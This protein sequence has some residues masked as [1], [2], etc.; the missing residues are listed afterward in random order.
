MARNLPVSNK[1]RKLFEL[2]M[3]TAAI[4]EVRGYYHGAVITRGSRVLAQGI[5][6]K[7]KTHPLA[8]SRWTQH[9]EFSVIMRLGLDYLREQ[10]KTILYSAR[11]G[12]G[13]VPRMS[14]PCKNCMNWILEAGIDQVVYWD[15]ASKEIQVRKVKDLI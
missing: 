5:N 12:P 14:K 9:A 10:G 15:R 3:T 7:K 2:A 8:H 4:S 6:T 13:G 1:H 11:R